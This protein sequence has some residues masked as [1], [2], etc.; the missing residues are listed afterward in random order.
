MHIRIITALFCAA[1]F[2][3]STASADPRNQKT[4]LTFNRSVQLPGVELGPGTYVFKVPDFNYRHVVQVFNADETKLLA[5]IIANSSERQ[6]G[7]D[8][9]ALRFGEAPR[10][11]PEPLLTWFYPQYKIGKEFIYSKEQRREM[12]QVTV[13]SSTAT[14]TTTASTTSTEAEADRVAE[15]EIKTE[16]TEPVQQAEV[17]NDEHVDVDADL[18][19]K[20][21]SPVVAAEPQPEVELTGS[22]DREMDQSPAPERTTLPAT[23]TGWLAM[24]LGGGALLGAGIAV[25]KQFV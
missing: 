17:R 5:T 2:F 21:E 10:D 6:F 16:V 9:T 15:A 1:L 19:A 24:I 7:T 12:A 13:P 18:E 8:R 3:S 22:A 23:N 14:I 11:M 25:R 20:V 4:I